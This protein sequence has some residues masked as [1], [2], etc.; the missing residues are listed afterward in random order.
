MLSTST[1]SPGSQ[2]AII[3]P[4][5]GEDLA[6]RINVSLEMLLAQLREKSARVELLEARN[7][8]L[9]TEN[10]SLRNA[11]VLLLDEGL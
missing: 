2:P 3:V 1:N 8:E 5:T 4:A 11:H 6:A 7:R 10:A 9:E